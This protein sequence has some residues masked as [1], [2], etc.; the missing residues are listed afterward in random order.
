MGTKDNDHPYIIAYGKSMTEIESFYIE[1]EKHLIPVCTPC[2]EN[3]VLWLTELIDF[4]QIPR[5]FSFNQVFDTFVKLHKV[6]NL[7]F[8]PALENMMI[9]IQQFFYGISDTKKKATVAMKELHN[10]LC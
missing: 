8:D 3:F 7:N 5:N 1:V 10:N 9:Y 4:F 2:N 6:L